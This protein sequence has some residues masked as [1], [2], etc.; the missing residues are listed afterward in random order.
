MATLATTSRSCQFVGAAY[1]VIPWRAE[2]RLRRDAIHDATL[3]LEAV[4]WTSHKECSPHAS[5]ASATTT[6]G[7]SQQLHHPER[8]SARDDGI[9]IVNNNNDGDDDDEKENNTLEWDDSW[10]AAKGSTT[11][12]HIQCADSL[13]SNCSTPSVSLCVAPALL[14]DVTNPT[15]RRRLG[16]NHRV[17]FNDHVEVF[18]IVGCGREGSEETYDVP[19]RRKAVAHIDITV[20]DYDNYADN[21]DDGDDHGD[22]DDL[23]SIGAMDN[24][25]LT[26]SCD[27]AR[28]TTQRAVV[29]RAPPPLC[30]R[31]C[32]STSPANGQALAILSRRTRRATSPAMRVTPAICTQHGARR[33][34]VAVYCR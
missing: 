29:G 20:E 30:H 10:I 25:A 6:T 12:M 5:A 24:D 23:V 34:T 27:H 9:D 16:F 8:A 7:C 14:Q 19:P 3:L 32:R 31:T 15:R 18:E 2:K 26:P 21:H 4:G 13:R 22:K 33:A 1:D 11:P 28:V 17:S